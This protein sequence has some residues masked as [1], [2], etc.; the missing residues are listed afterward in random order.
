MKVKVE[1]YY[2]TEELK[3]TL[4]IGSAGLSIYLLF[5]TTLW[6]IPLILI[7]LVL[8]LFSTKSITT[9]D[10]S[11]K[12][13]KDEFQFLWIRTKCEKIKFKTLDKITID[14]ERHTYTANS[15]GR[16]GVTDFNEY[17]G[18]LI[19]DNNRIVELKRSI[20]LQ[21]F[22]NYIKNISEK[23]NLEVERLF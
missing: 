2:F 15:R 5:W 22:D 12:L 13:I 7:V 16:S 8:I 9:I 14:K 23:L 6:W 18:N 21:D 11:Q 17:I 10:I 20:S 19:F 3:W 1:D 4:T